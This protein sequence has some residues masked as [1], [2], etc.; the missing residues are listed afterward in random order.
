MKRL[1]VAI[2][3]SSHL[4]KYEENNVCGEKLRI[5]IS[6]PHLKIYPVVDLLVMPSLGNLIDYHSNAN[7]EQ[8]M[9]AY[10]RGINAFR[11][12]LEFHK[13]DSYKD[14]V[15]RFV[16]CLVD[17]DNEVVLET[18]LKA[19]FKSGLTIKTCLKAENDFE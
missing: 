7:L 6:I 2:I 14:L 9:Q 13:A 18:D 16:T 11:D 4:V 8:D 17:E 19:D 15:G 3:N 1:H 12:A 10:I 5:G